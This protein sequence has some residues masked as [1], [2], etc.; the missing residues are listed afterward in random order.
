ML[1]FVIKPLSF[2]KLLKFAELTKKNYSDVVSD[3]V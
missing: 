3:V 1:R 2:A